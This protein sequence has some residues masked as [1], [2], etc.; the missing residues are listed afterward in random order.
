MKKKILTICILSLLI[1]NLVGCNNND[2]YYVHEVMREYKYKLE[3]TGTLPN[4][5]GESTITVY[6]NEENLTFEQVVEVMF[7]YSPDSEEIKPLDIYVENI[8]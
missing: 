7:Q 8:E 3:L 2:G 6:S 4:T 5:E 1:F